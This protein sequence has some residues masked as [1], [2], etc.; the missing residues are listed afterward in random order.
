[1]FLGQK[2]VTNSSNLHVL[3]VLNFIFHQPIISAQPST[4]NDISF[5]IDEDAEFS[6]NDFHDLV[7]S[8]DKD[9][10]VESVSLI[11]EFTHPKYEFFILC[12]CL[13]RVNV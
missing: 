10:L 9:G 8:V 12:M 7:R 3:F 2:Q 5:W 13:R 11:D 1:M 6:C 4:I